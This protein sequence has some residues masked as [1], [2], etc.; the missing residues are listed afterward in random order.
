MAK[1][2]TPSE[3]PAGAIPFVLT[4][5]E[6]K[7]NKGGTGAPAPSHLSYGSVKSKQ[8]RANAKFTAE[9]VA[10]LVKNAVEQQKPELKVT[11]K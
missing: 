2:K 7:V 4:N 1:N 10:E 5:P 9:E 6:D 11:S 8:G 3:I